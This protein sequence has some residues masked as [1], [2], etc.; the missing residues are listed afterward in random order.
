MARIVKKKVLKIQFETTSPLSL[1]NGE[2]I[3]TD[4]DVLLDAIGKPFIPGSAIAGVILSYVKDWKGEGD[5]SWHDYFGFVEI[6]REIKEDVEIK[7]SRLS[8]SDATLDSGKFYVTRRDSV[9][10]DEFKTAKNHAKFDMEVVEPGVCF[11]SIIEQN[12][13]TNQDED[14]IQE[15]FS[16]FRNEE[17]SFGKKTSRGLGKIKL[18]KAG[19]KEFDFAKK[20]DINSWL[21]FDVDDMEMEE[22]CHRDEAYLSNDKVLCLGLRLQGGISIREYTTD[23][24]KDK[25]DVV[26]DFRQL[27]EHIGNEILPVIPGTS[28][29]GAFIH[30]M[31]RN[32]P[33]C[34][35]TDVIDDGMKKKVFYFG[36]VDEETKTKAR[37]S[38]EFS[39]TVINGGID[40]VITR[41]AIDHKGL[42]SA[43]ADLHAGF[44][45]VGGSTSIGRGIFKVTSINGKPFE[46]KPEDLYQIIIETLR[47]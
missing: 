6:N 43:V 7:E 15:I 42:A 20:E 3:N 4:S 12:F 39:E 14:Y 38:V 18:L 37:S 23:L 41:N 9:A 40:K 1:S 19:I 16:F 25:D 46:G 28:W 26:A 45:A 27:T 34:D 22:D 32:V 33:G 30:Q 10:L 13:L 47:S 24:R 31:K 11:T 5:T 2:D 8:F 21:D 44:M 17:I 36:Y 35:Q 29:A